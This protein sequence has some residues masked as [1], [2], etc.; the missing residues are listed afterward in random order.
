M[1]ATISEPIHISAAIEKDAALAEFLATVKTTARETEL[2]IA[3]AKPALARIASAIARHDNG[4]AVRLRALLISL[5]SGGRAPVD[6]SELMMLDWSLRKDLCAVLCAFGHGEFGYDYMK[7]AFEQAG[8]FEAQWFLAAAPEPRERLRTALHFAK[9]GNAREP[10]SSGERRIRQFLVS[11]FAGVP[12]DLQDVLN[13]LDAERAKL[14]L[15]IVSDYL[16]GRFDFT[17]DEE[18]RAR[19]ALSRQ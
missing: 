1:T 11:L 18:V 16:A 9:A 3:E 5:Y 19:F 8:D 2:A 7:S 12:V 14:V 17:D 10:R 15:S 6:L 13:G 4:Q